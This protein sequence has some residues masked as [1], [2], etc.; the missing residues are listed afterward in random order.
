M[1]GLLLVFGLI[2][3]SD[4]NHLRKQHIDPAPDMKVNEIW[5]PS[6]KWWNHDMIHGLFHHDDGKDVLHFPLLDSVRQD[7]E[8]WQLSKNDMCKV[9]VYGIQ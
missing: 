8:V 7:K 5:V 6:E 9:I 3:G 1:I 2:L 4:D